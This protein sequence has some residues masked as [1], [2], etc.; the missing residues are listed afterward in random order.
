MK[1]DRLESDIK[2]M[3]D[4]G[5]DSEALYKRAINYMKE[6][7]DYRSAGLSPDEVEMLRDFGE[8]QHAKL[9][10]ENGQLENDNAAM[11]QEWQEA[12]AELKQLREENDRYIAVNKKLEEMY[13]DTQKA[14]ALACRFFEGGPEE[15]G[16]GDWRLLQRHFMERVQNEQVCRVC[17]CTQDNACLDVI[18]LEPCIWAE[19]DLCSH[20]VETEEALDEP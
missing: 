8:E 19:L 7:K 10:A 3:Q 1:K 6:L 5:M 4:V 2:R 17:G 13:W 16:P 9:L 18:S 12:H 20:C 11:K 15:G 14:F